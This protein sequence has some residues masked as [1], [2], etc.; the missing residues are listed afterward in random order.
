[1][2]ETIINLIDNEIKKL[3]QTLANKKAIISKEELTKLLS[4]LNDFSSFDLS[5]L[6]NLNIDKET[7]KKLEFY[8]FVLLS[9]EE[10]TESQL[11][12]IN[13]LKATI[14]SKLKELEQSSETS[15]IAVYKELKSKI[16]NLSQGSY[17][18]TDDIKLLKNLLIAANINMDS[19]IEIMTYLSI[20]SLTNLSQ[21]KS[22]TT[23]NSSDEIIELPIS[24]LDYS[25]VKE[26]F[27][28][29][30][31]TF[32]EMTSEA[33]K[34]IL[35]HASM[36]N[37]ESIFQVLSQNGIRL[38]ELYAQSE[39]LA[40]L[41][42]MALPS[43][44]QSVIN[45]MKE[46]ISQGNAKDSLSEIFK[47]YLQN[48][49]IFIIGYKKYSS[50]LFPAGSNPNGNYVP[51]AY[52]NYRENRKLFLKLGLKDINKA[53]SKAGSIFVTN[54]QKIKKMVEIFDFYQIPRE[55]YI[56]SLTALISS[57]DSLNKIDRFIELGL[58]D[59]I[60]HNLSLLH[61][62]RYTHSIFY[63]LTK[64]KQEGIDFAEFLTYRG[65]SAQ[66]TNEKITYLGIDKN[67]GPALTGEY[68][69]SADNEEYATYEKI[70]AESENSGPLVLVWSNPFIKKLETLKKDEVTY[71]FN[72][73]I[74]SRFK[75]LRLFETLLLNNSAN[76]LE[77]LVF[78][79]TKY[80][81]L[82]KE[83][84][85][86]IKNCIYKLYDYKGVKR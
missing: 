23:S 61:T 59:Y 82:T 25:T 42:T 6:T 44:I 46:N 77:S 66:I 36:T 3:E 72:G 67:N 11:Q 81:I 57:F 37:L 60:R 19:K 58:F 71:D 22:N 8:Q 4:Q 76:T 63:K 56:N 16:T 47:D 9:G 69:P 14:Q 5:A 45:D 53:V 73:I 10:L 2:S 68:N 28:K 12:S 54:H 62:K 13:D 32:D 79:I 41:F 26:L 65:L 80:S 64:A 38:D 17:L 51:G 78:V 29:Y 1:M 34:K 27:S 74:I 31:Y 52:H 70:I 39:K 33:Q 30:H 85:E 43:T 20:A 7:S 40:N 49:V 18:S 86:T 50:T 55:C 35:T 24:N 83:Q 84:F 15:K 48:E 75:V 21:L